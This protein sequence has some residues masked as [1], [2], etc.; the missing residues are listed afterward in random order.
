MVQIAEH[1]IMKSQHF[2]QQVL[3]AILHSIYCI[4]LC[5]KLLD[6]SLCNGDPTSITRQGVGMTWGTLLLPGEHQIEIP[7]GWVV[8]ET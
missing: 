5:V 3:H 4:C 8:Q 2:E 1:W 6:L 7:P